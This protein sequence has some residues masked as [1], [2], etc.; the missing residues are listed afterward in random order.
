M[1]TTQDNLPTVHNFK[2]LDG[3]R[4]GTLVV[5]QYA[6]AS[7][8]GSTL[9]LCECDCGAVKVVASGNLQR[10]KSCGARIH[11]AGVNST[12]GMSRS[13]EYSTW[14]GMKSRCYDEKDGSYP[15]YG[16]R[17]ITVC[18]EW[19]QSFE[20]FYLD[21]G[22]RPSNKHSIDRIDS[23]GNYNPENCR[24]SDAK[25][26]ARNTRSNRLL[27]IDGHTQCVAAWAEEVGVKP[28]KIINRLRSGHAPRD[29]VFF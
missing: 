5:M 6:G 29:A 1:H 20:R 2:N 13:T 21:M 25:A 23:N 16:G 8:S 11:K 3:C 18:K 9:W 26:Q 19:R 24:W 14:S 22:A 7:K 4:F 28:M 15:R 17:G 27:T 10:Q 12:H